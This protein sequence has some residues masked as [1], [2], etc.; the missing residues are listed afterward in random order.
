MATVGFPFALPAGNNVTAGFANTTHAV[1]NLRINRDPEVAIIQT[2]TEEITL[3]EY[4]SHVVHGRPENTAPSEVDLE[5]EEDPEPSEEDDYDWDPVPLT[6]AEIDALCASPDFALTPEN[7]VLSS[8]TAFLKSYTLQHSSSTAFRFGGLLGSLA[9]THIGD[10]NLSCG[11][12]TP[13]RCA[14]SCAS[15]VR[16]L[17]GNLLEARAVYFTFVSAQHLAETLRSLSNGLQSAQLNVGQMSGEFA[18]NFFGST[19]K[20]ADFIKYALKLSEFI[21]SQLIG[22]IAPGFKPGIVA[23]ILPHQYDE[24]KLEAERFGATLARFQ[25]EMRNNIRLGRA[26]KAEKDQIKIN[27]IEG[28]LQLA[29]QRKQLLLDTYHT[30]KATFGLDSETP[31]SSLANGGTVASMGAMTLLGYWKDKIE[32]G[33]VSGGSDRGYTWDKNSME[34]F[35]S[36]TTSMA[37]QA[38]LDLAEEIFLGNGVLPD[39]SGRTMFS[40]IISAGNFLPGD[41][42]S[43]VAYYHS[44][45]L[46]Q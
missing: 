45:G 42:S 1:K 24:A 27:G 34:S 21:L 44:A 2:A 41:S 22:Y 25:A 38:V 9:S 6:T 17:Q 5:E 32:S 4:L 36:I 46:E 28:M 35:I 15:V 37:R 13:H 3:S 12:N 31:D 43:D 40:D 39:G 26:K 8:T 29:M 33:F 7:F 18:H 14:P 19:T 30:V 16:K 23:T 11:L 10:P 20:D